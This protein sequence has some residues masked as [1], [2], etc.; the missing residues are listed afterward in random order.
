MKT[1]LNLL[2]IEDKPADLRL[3]ERHLQTQGLPARCHCVASLEALKAAVESEDWDAVLSD[4]S[5]PQLD[6]HEALGVVQTRHPDLP[7]ILVS[8]SIGEEK[9]VELFKLGVSDF[10]LKDNL[11]RL[12]P[13]LKRCK[14]EA[15]ERRARRV[16]E[17]ALQESEV[18]FRSLF[19]NS[20]VGFYR[21]TPDG[22]ILMA[23]P[24]LL[25]LLGFS[26][27]E[28]LTQR[29]LEQ[30]GFAPEYSRAAFK[31]RLER[32][33]QI[34][35]LEAAWKRNDGS[36][37]FVRENCQVVRDESGRTLYYDGSIEDITERKQAEQAQELFRA[38]VERSSDAIHV[39]DPTTGRFLDFNESACRSLGYTRQELKE[40]TVF[41]VTVAVGQ[42][43]FK[44][45]A[46]RMK[47]TGHVTL[48][49]VHR[50]KDGTTYPVEVSLSPVLLDREYLVAIVRDITT[51]KAA[52]RELQENEARLSVIFQ[53]SPIGIITSRLEDGRIAEVNPAFADLYGYTRDEMVGR[54]SC[55]LQ[56]WSIPAQRDALIQ[57]LRTRG[58]CQDHE[59]KARRKTGEVRD[60]LISAQL[61]TMSGEPYMLG[62]ARDITERKRIEES[63][64]QLATVVQQ[65]TEAIAIT[66]PNGT[67]LYVNPAFERT[68]GYSGA[69]AVG[70]NPRLLKS[71]K[72]DPEF[73]RQM[74]GMLKRGEVWSGHFV[75]RR[76]D[77]TLYEEE[78]TISP[79]RDT[80]GSIVNYVAVKRDVTREVQLEAQYRQAQ[81]MEAIGTLA[82]GIAHDF[83]NILA[84]IFGF[85]YLLQQ[86]TA[87]NVTAQES[88]EEI[89][90]ATSRAKDLVQQILTFSRQ[91]E[92]KRQVIR[93]DTV[94]KEAMK[95]LRASLPAQINIDLDLAADTPTVLADATQI[96]QVTMNLATNAMHAMEGRTGQL[97]VRLDSFAPDAQFIRAHPDVHEI[98][99]ARLTVA[100][101][102]TGMDAKTLD[103]IFEPFFTT[104]P[105]GKGTGLG[106]AV[107]HGIVQA[108][109]GVLTVES[110]VGRGTTFCLYF[111]A[112][113]QPEVTAA[114]DTGQL[115]RGQGQKILV[116]D[117][118]LAL[119]VMF[120]K[121]LR[122]L[123]YDVTTANR[124]NEAI[125]LFRENPAQFGL[126]ITDLNMPEMDG[127]EVARRLRDL[128]ADVPVVLASGY[129]ASLTDEVLR[130]AGICALLE[131]PIA[132]PA[133]A[134]IVHRHLL[135]A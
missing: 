73:Y 48:E 130:E 128:R 61:I 123:N 118:E 115:P 16:A 43:F 75:N 60:L 72:Q 68:S 91:R 100:D 92:Q 77:G 71:G 15:A 55:E 27:L 31:E 129:T 5:V 69:E 94:V 124:A 81:K 8:G 26:S 23:N 37:R 95:F 25:K 56:L 41:D 3:L 13:S 98:N 66:D 45:S 122:R 88:V 44:A 12:V 112:Q 39:V 42:A 14:R 101:T 103:R 19:D 131:K 132:L 70:Q 126:V 28:E 134:E 63:H 18:R 105:Q 51:R 9:A 86:D 135:R 67:I 24:A 6:F 96:Y 29:N 97:T 50:R 90:R 38:L 85:G 53:H 104:K 62:L 11:A 34:R 133:L 76:K 82:G 57:Q 36:I 74:W 121:L 117:D 22:R 119:S 40:L 114:A 59:I 107:V 32:E 58:S 109:D 108:H 10:V 4:Y 47:Q 111:P 49:A 21:T 20:V 35:G 65:A 80:T 1:P 87:G 79:V 89:L 7:V 127:L 116:L 30:E 64:A 2:I 33:G 113:R 120:G 83:N 93:L 125:R 110:Q 99:Y 84:A 52:E 17:T 54:L 102:G 78:A 46:A 106:L